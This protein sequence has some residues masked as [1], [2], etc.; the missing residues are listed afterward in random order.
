MPFTTTR[1]ISGE[2]RYPNELAEF[3]CDLNRLVK[4]SSFSV[5][6]DYKFEI[7]LE[8]FEEDDIQ[9]TEIAQL[10][11]KYCENKKL[12]RPVEFVCRTV[13]N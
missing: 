6:S 7:C 12:F 2:C 9:I 1:V 3:I 10:I 5:D 11:E 4:C 8:S 13:I